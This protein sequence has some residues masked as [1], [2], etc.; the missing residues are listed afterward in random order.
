MH[1]SKQLTFM[2]LAAMFSGTFM[3]GPLRKHI[4]QSLYKREQMFLR[5]TQYDVLVEDKIAAI[6]ADIKTSPSDDKKRKYD[7]MHL[8]QTIIQNPAQFMQDYDFT[9]R[10]ATP[11]CWGLLNSCGKCSRCLRTTC[12]TCLESHGDG[13]GGSSQ[14]YCEPDILDT[15]A[16]IHTDSK[17]CPACGIYIAK[18]DGCS[19]VW[20]TN[21]HVAFDFGTLRFERQ[22]VHAPNFYE[23]QRE[24]HG[25]Q[26]PASTYTPSPLMDDVIDAWLHT[27]YTSAQLTSIFDFYNHVQHIEYKCL[28]KY[29]HPFTVPDNVNLRKKYVRGKITQ[30][31]FTNRLWRA[32]KHRYKMIEYGANLL[33]YVVVGGNIIRD[34]MDNSKPYEDI[35]ER[36]NTLIANT[37]ATFEY[38]AAVFNTR[39]ALKLS[40]M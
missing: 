8:K 28:M 23:H 20:C 4:Q 27:I 21:C 24:L 3:H 19:Q 9:K 36:M 32:E 17:P 39:K 11:D 16:C 1:C 38:V 35:F 14:H 30:A 22:S 25:G 6:N 31:Q 12:L 40:E 15:M 34:S 26:V 33:N 5:E 10:C 18:V 37:D 7:L 13:D 29:P 2:D